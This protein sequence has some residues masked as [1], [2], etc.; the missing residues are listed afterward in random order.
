MDMK[1]SERKKKILRALAT[2]NIKTA[3]PV[4]SQ[5]LANRY[6]SDLSSATIR[7]ELAA[8]EEQGIISKTHTSS[9]RVPTMLGFQLFIDEI[10]PYV[11]PTAQELNQMRKRVESRVGE[12]E[13]IVSKAAEALSDACDLPSVV[14]SGITP[15]ALIESVNIFPV[16]AFDCFV[17]V[18]TNEGYI[19]DVTANSENFDA[20]ACQSASVY[21]SKTL[22]GK[23]IGE[24]NK[25]NV[26]QEFKSFKGIIVM[27]FKV[28]E[29]QQSGQ[30]A[31]SGHSKLL[32]VDSK[33]AKAFLELI[34]NKPRLKE[35]IEQNKTD[36]VSVSVTKV[37]DADCAVVSALV[38]DK[39]G[40]PLSIAVMG[41]ARMD[42]E[43]AIKAVRGISKIIDEGGKL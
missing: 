4:S 13:N 24:I 31:A 18:K 17:V 34:D 8:M 29:S 32:D 38:H 14:L 2:E 41:P 42:Y 10:L 36:S 11:R 7:N 9:G 37:D 43:K 19:K 35:I 26:E 23:R 21:L 5:Q 3:E 39:T 30:I 20:E 6:F 12:M 27:L 40:K 1:M 25:A 28:I 15:N 33:S 16:S 22:F